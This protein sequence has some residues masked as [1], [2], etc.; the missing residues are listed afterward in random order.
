MTGEIQP[1]K[2]PETRVGFL[3]QEVQESLDTSNC[4]YKNIVSLRDNGYYALDYSRIICPLIS[5]VQDLQK[6]VDDLQAQVNRAEPTSTKTT[7]T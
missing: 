1:A 6:K 4:I 3:A 5:V 7:R 2:P